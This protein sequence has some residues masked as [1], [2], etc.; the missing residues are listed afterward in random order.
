MTIP[1]TVNQYIII[2]ALEGCRVYLCNCVH[3]PHCKPYCITASQMIAW[4]FTS[5]LNA[6][7]MQKQLEEKWPN[8]NWSIALVCEEPKAETVLLGDQSQK[9]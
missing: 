7:L 9:F 5:Y 6:T 3:T 1:A 8:H 2:G 4:R